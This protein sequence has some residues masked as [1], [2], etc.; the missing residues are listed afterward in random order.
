M[1]NQQELLTA[2][3][4][5]RDTVALLV[6]TLKEDYPKRTEIKQARFFAGVY[7]IIGLII[8]ALVSSFITV[9]IVSGCFLSKAALDGNANPV[10]SG[11]PGYTTAQARNQQTRD[12]FEHLIREIDKNQR[13][14][15]VL[16]QKG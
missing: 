10:C 14:I 9:T 11:L 6:S 1:P 16:Q 2:V 12:R 8:S 13:E 3:Q 15:K 4:D 7:V 5:L